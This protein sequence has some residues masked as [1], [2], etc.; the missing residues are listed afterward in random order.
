MTGHGY[1][2][3]TH[4]RLH[5]KILFPKKN[6]SFQYAFLQIST[7][8]LQGYAMGNKTLVDVLV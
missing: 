4:V 6:V 8:T 7:K 2:T 3:S 1:I 5:L